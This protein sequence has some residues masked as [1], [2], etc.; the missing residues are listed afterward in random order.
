MCVC[1]CVCDPV[2][3]CHFLLFVCETCTAWCAHPAC[4]R[5]RAIKMH[6]L[7]LSDVTAPPRL[8]SLHGRHGLWGGHLAGRRAA[9]SQ[10]QER[11]QRPRSALLHL[12][13]RPRP[14]RATQQGHRA[15][16]QR[17]Q[18]ARGGHSHVAQRHRSPQS[19]VRR[20]GAADCQRG[21]QDVRG[22]WAQLL[23]NPSFYEMS[24][25]MTDALP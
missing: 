2:H 18:A 23:A 11:R 19:R 21:V 10:G 22:R 17:S 16:H 13:A 4:A 25:V 5:Y 6:L 3:L 20:E 7:L 14:A 9:H 15:G 24:F 8:H 12:P 1:V